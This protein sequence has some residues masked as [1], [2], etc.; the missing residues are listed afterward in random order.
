M[1]RRTIVQPTALAGIHLTLA[2]WLPPPDPASNW[3]GWLRKGPREYLVHPDARSELLRQ[4]ETAL[5][6]AGVSPVVKTPEETQIAAVAA[7]LR[8]RD[9]ARAQQEAE[10]QRTLKPMAPT[11]Q[12]KRT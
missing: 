10:R 11:V 3:P 2:V 12:R 4:L 5:T 9:L 6:E 1:S 8:T 7:A